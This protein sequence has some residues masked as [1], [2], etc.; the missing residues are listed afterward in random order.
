[1]Y[2]LEREYIEDGGKLEVRYGGDVT[3]IKPDDFVT[4]AKDLKSSRL[5]FDAGDALA[6]KETALGYTK[7]LEA[8]VLNTQARLRKEAYDNASQWAKS[9]AAAIQALSAPVAALGNM[10]E[11]IIDTSALLVGQALNESGQDN[12]RDFVSKDTIRID[13]FMREALPNSYVYPPSGKKTAWSVTYDTVD[14]ISKI[15]AMVGL[16][17][18]GAHIGMPKLGTVAY[19]A[20]MAGN[21]AE[22]TFIENPNMTYE[23]ASLYTAGSTIIELGVESLSGNMTFGGGVFKSWERLATKNT[24]FKIL[25]ESI[26]E[27]LEEVISNVGSDIWYAG[28]TGK[29]VELDA[30]ELAYSALLGGLIGGITAVGSNVYM[31]SAT[32]KIA[33]SVTGTAG[34]I[35]S[36]TPRQLA[37]MNDYVETMQMRIDDGG[38]AVCKKS[39]AF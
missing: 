10:A 6:A 14:G 29:R 19:Y 13:T 11:G 28:V 15:G 20:G 39:S 27:G 2:A 34:N 22:Q 31:N 1:M 35:V 5:A 9:S 4:S 23:Q 18:L 24:A 8:V 37:M 17:Y 36:L 38:K 12:V 3:L 16:N 7:Y 32:K 30:G 26:G 33:N 25:K 21:T